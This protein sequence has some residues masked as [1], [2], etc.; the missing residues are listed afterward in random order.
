MKIAIAFSIAV[1]GSSLVGMSIG[2]LIR[3]FRG[4]PITPMIL[5]YVFFIGMGSLWLIM[6]FKM[7]PSSN[8]KKD[9]WSAEE[10]EVEGYEIEVKPK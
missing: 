9:E 6:G 4:E 8:H 10:V 2:E 5:A 7:L 1:L 3:F